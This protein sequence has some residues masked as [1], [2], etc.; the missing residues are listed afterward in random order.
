MDFYQ[1]DAFT[2]RPFAGNPAAVVFLESFP[3]N[4]W[5]Q[6]VAAEMNLAETAFL[7]PT[8]NAVYD[9]RWFTPVAEVDLCGHATL[10]SAHVLWESGR[11]QPGRRVGFDTRSG[12]LSAQQ[13]DD[14]LVL[15]FPAENP[16]ELDDDM[17]LPDALGAE[18]VYIAGNR[19]D[20]L[21]ELENEAAVRSLEPDLHALEQLGF[22][23]IIVTARAEDQPYDFVSRYFAPRFG[24]PED[25]VTGSAHC[26]L[27]PYWMD[28]LG[29]TSMVGY[30]ASA[31]GGTVGVEITNDRVLLK[32]KAITIL[33]GHLHPA[34]S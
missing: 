17:G 9:L 16:E 26:C 21:V 27:A 10:A 4:E 8:A 25:P 28:K 31:R 30:Q 5:L 11:I 13:D 23:G 18:P 6:H 12:R 20:V 15:D 32:G 2:D 22:R 24:I 14:E 29:K 34:P 3:S 7:V 33:S 19:L 1:V